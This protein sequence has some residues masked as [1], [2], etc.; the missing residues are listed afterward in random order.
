MKSLLTSILL[1]TALA[2][3]PLY[4]FVGYYVFKYM[5]LENFPDRGLGFE[6]MCVLSGVWISAVTAAIV[7]R[8]LS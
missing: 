4:A 1:A 6:I 3:I 8:E 5:I 7:R 2:A